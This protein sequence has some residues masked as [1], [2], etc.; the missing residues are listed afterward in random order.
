MAGVKDPMLLATGNGPLPWPQLK[1]LLKL[2][3]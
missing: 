3:R 2:S 1:T